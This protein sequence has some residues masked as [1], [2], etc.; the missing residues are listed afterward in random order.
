MA[1]ELTEAEKK[2]ASGM[3]QLEFD[4]ENYF[5]TAGQFHAEPGKKIIVSSSEI[6][7]DM[8]IMMQQFAM[9]GTG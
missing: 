4:G 5:R 2:H 3:M 1:D 7:R 8:E 6:R 9:Y